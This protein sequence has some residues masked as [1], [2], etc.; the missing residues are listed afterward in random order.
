MY[1]TTIKV[2][3]IVIIPIKLSRFYS[4]LFK[5]LEKSIAF[6]NL[7]DKLSI[8]TFE[9]NFTVEV[10]QYTFVTNTFLLCILLKNPIVANPTEFRNIVDNKKIRKTIVKLFTAYNSTLPRILLRNIKKYFPKVRI[11]E[12]LI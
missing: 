2:F 5:R 11:L 3:E 9:N 4:F 10:I 12:S 7:F 1:S 6:D 8:K